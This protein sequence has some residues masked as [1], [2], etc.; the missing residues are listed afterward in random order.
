[1]PTVVEGAVIGRAKIVRL[2]GEGATG[3][4][5]LCQHTT[6]NVP[7]ALKILKPLGSASGEAQ[8]RERFRREAQLVARIDHPGIVRVIDFGEYDSKPWIL[9]EYVDG[10]T[11]EQ[12][13]G[14][15]PQ[16]IAEPIVL[17]VLESLSLALAAAHEQGVIHRDLKPANILVSRKGALKIADFGLARDDVSPALTMGGIAV[18]SPQYMPPEAFTQGK[19]VDT[20]GDIYSLG[21]LAY[22]LVFGHTP[23]RGTVPQIIQGHLSGIADLSGPSHCSRATLAI[24][25]RMLSFSPDDRY[26]SVKELLA[27]IRKSIAARS[28]SGSSTSVRSKTSE[29]SQALL[30]KSTSGVSSTIEGQKIV[31]TTRSERLIIW[32]ILAGVAIIAVLS[33]LKY[34]S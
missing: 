9:M 34:G 5:Y 16:G 12:T 3:S 2:L 27:D 4:V 7:V 15:Y 18:G 33:F 31:H 6:L 20:R 13:L 11:L 17:K 19:K 25:K 23:F 8:W 28:Q 22:H 10:T 32:L 30:A 26:Q 21:I 24:I 14:R 1:M 29:I